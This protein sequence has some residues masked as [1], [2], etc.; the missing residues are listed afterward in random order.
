M[1]RPILGLLITALCLL[2]AATTRAGD[3]VLADGGQSAYRIVVADEASPSTRHAAEELQ[4]FLQQMSGA[5]LPIVSDREP[6]GAQEIVLG[7]NAHLRQL[8]L[9]IDLPALGR[10]GYVIR[11][12]GQQLVI[13]GG[14]QRGN[15]YGVYGLLEDHLG[16]RWFA[17]DV[18]RIPKTPRLAIGPI[19]ERKVPVLE[20]REPFTFD[21]FDGDWCARN[22]MNS[23]SGRL[24]EKHGGKIMFAPGFFCHTFASLVPP[25]KYFKEHPEYFSLVG[26]KRQ[27]GY[28]QLCCTNEDVIRLCTEGILK[29]MK[30]H[31][32]AFVFSVSQNDVD[33]HCECD[34][35]QA[36]ARQE[37]SQIAPVLALVNRVAEAAEKDFPDKAVETLAYQWTRRPPKTMRPRPNVIIRLCSIECCFAHPLEKCDS[38]A[39]RAFCRDLEGWSKLSNRLWVWDYVTD[40]SH[41]LMPFPNQRVRDDNI[42]LFV[43]NNVKGIFEQDTYNSPHS[44]LAALGGYLTAKYLWNPDYDENTAMTEFLD[45]YYGPAAKPIRDY[46]DLIH[47][48]VEKNHIHVVIWAPPTSAHVTDELLT[49]ADRLWQEAERLAGSDAAV[50]KRVQLGRMS[51]DY[52]IVERVRAAA[53]KKDSAPSPLSALAVHRFQPFV[54]TLA[55]SGLTRL[56][57]WKQLDIADYRAKLAAALGVKP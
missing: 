8:G 25:D 50:L 21:C 7:E 51:V 13:A 11:T 40:F 36:L 10:E 22:R 27:D 47:D 33:K 20:Y 23:S 34:R 16:C 37:D 1:S 6:L 46:L 55:A 35:C 49:E 5:K 19:D 41:Y 38:P 48:Y 30:A 2:S 45:A 18:S 28:A 31:P 32:E 39:N 29:G 3:L 53:G 43:R 57:E 26:G 14:A 9:Q 54:Q 15:L 12:A 44:E 17:P 52:A 24:E 4:M 56:H 42:R